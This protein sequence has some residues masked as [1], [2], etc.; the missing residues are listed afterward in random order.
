MTVGAGGLGAS[1]FMGG[2]GLGDNALGMFLGQNAKT[3]DREALAQAQRMADEGLDQRSIWDETGWFQGA[4]DKWR[5]EIDDSDAGLTDFAAR[6][7][8]DKDF[9]GTSAA[10]GFN[11]PELFKAYEDEEPFW[12]DYNVKIATPREGNYY[13]DNDLVSVNAPTQR[14]ARDI[15]LHEFQHATQRREGFAKGGNPESAVDDFLDRV[16]VDLRKTS[17]EM[18]ALR[19]KKYAM[20]PTEFD[21]Q[22][23]VLRSQ[24]DGLL[25]ERSAGTT[26]AAKRDGYKRLA[27]E[28]EARNVQTRR[29]FT[30]DQ[31]KATA[32]WET[33]DV[34]RDQQIVR[35]GANGPQN[36]MG[37]FDFT[38]RERSFM[39][40]MGGRKFKDQDD[41]RRQLAY[42]I[43]KRNTAKGLF[44]DS[45][46]PEQFAPDFLDRIPLVSHGKGVKIGA[47]GKTPTTREAVTPS[48]DPI[49]RAPDVSWGKPDLND[50]TKGENFDQVYIPVSQIPK[51][52]LAGGETGYDWRE[53]QRGGSP[54][55]VTLKQN[56]NGSLS[57]V[58]GNHRLHFFL[59][60]DYDS[61]PVKLIRK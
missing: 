17:R 20:D 54:P 7:L 49:G 39:D 27:G 28:V 4:D 56:K 44:D 33:E 59:Q 25:S 47:A 13:A 42:H 53:L 37:K 5:F 22:M 52:K 51:P 58:D 18:D 8:F 10:S 12:G 29:D 3:A 2:A 16:N 6:R 11:H 15:S 19:S 9:V 48:P 50:Y 31:R 32:P 60:Q 45:P 57:I 35:F 46:P 24:Y 55:P 61:I 38:D 14:D 23:G 26:D 36:A 43:E 40:Y 30:P 41:A 1:T 21:E 34:P